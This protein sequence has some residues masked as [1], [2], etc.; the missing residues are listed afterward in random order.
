MFF[1]PVQDDN[2]F[3]IPAYVYKHPCVPLLLNPVLENFPAPRL[4]QCQVDPPYIIHDQGFRV[5]AEQLVKEQELPAQL[6]SPQQFITFALLATLQTVTNPA[7]L[8]WAVGYLKNPD[9]NIEEIIKQM[10]EVLH[11]NNLPDPWYEISPVFPLLT[12]IQQ[13]SPYY[14]ACAAWSAVVRNPALD[15]GQLAV[16]ALTLD[17]FT[18]ATL[19]QDVYNKIKKEL[20]TYEKLRKSKWKFEWQ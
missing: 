8:Q 9:K 6:P 5:F 14:A 13:D 17:V 20:K 18:I 4:F 1:L 10:D 3:I 12:A 19:F 7:F 2:N 16:I 11:I 15:L